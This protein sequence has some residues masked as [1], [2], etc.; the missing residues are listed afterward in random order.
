[1]SAAAG[2]LPTRNPSGAAPPGLPR[3][4][5]IPARPGTPAGRRPAVAPRSQRRPRPRSARKPRPKAGRGKNRG[6]RGLWVTGHR[7]CSRPGPTC[8]PQPAS[9]AGKR[10]SRAR[11]RSQ[12]PRPDIASRDGRRHDGGRAVGRPPAHPRAR[13]LGVLIGG[14]LRLSVLCLLGLA[15]VGCRR[16]G[17]VAHSARLLTSC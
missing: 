16:R 5:S 4:R 12:T 9:S 15:R 14:T 10:R 3:G 7:E 8:S 11:A 2:T 17:L 6:D 1:M 13:L